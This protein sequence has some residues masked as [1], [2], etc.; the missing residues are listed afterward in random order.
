MGDELTA[1]ENLVETVENNDDFDAIWVAE[2]NEF[3]GYVDVEF[4][5]RTRSPQQ[6]DTLQSKVNS[7]A[8][9][10]PGVEVHRVFIC[11]QR[12]RF[13]AEAGR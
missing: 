5:G 6:A 3:D 1:L 11:D 2:H 7:T 9:T 10:L 12:V 4:D 8:P 13:V